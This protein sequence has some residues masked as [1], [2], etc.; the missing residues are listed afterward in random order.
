[1]SQSGDT[2]GN[3][4][5][6]IPQLPKQSSRFGVGIAQFLKEFPDKRPLRIICPTL[7]DLVENY[8]ILHN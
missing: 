5:L 2:L 8:L 7:L 6:L 4:T 3:R 1:M